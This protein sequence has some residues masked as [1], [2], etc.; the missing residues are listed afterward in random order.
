MWLGSQEAGG[1]KGWGQNKYLRLG[2]DT[3][4]SVSHSLSK[5]SD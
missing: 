4:S 1:L 3:E 5:I 2:K